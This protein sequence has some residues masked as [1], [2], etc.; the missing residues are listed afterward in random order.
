MTA[1]E[2]SP[3]DARAH[4]KLGELYGKKGEVILAASEYR[5]GLQLSGN[6]ELEKRFDDLNAGKGFTAAFA[7]IE[8]EKFKAALR[9]LD[10]RTAR[11]EYVSP[12]DYALLYTRLG[13][14]KQ[15]LAWLLRAYD[16][17]ATIMLELGSPI[18]DKIRDAP[19]FKEF[20]QRLRMPMIHAES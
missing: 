5:R 17:H 15:A 14:R 20:V 12:S 13:D 9:D 7:A 8:V 11:G 16:E 18:F 2:L 3:D 4:T 1:L 19:E 10:V 6:Q